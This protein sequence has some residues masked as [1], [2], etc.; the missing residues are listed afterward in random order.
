MVGYHFVL[1]E[2]EV[3]LYL[4]SFILFKILFVKFDVKV[5][6]MSL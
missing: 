5:Q 4:L 6:T 2:K 1:S 3:F